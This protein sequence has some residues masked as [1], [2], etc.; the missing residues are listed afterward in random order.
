MHQGLITHSCY[1]Y[2]VSNYAN[3]LFLYVIVPSIEVFVPFVATC[4]VANRI[5]I[6]HGVDQRMFR[7]CMSLHEID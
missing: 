4:R 3:P 7:S 1:L 5:E 2:L 6:G